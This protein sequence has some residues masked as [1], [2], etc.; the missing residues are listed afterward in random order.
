MSSRCREDFGLINIL[1]VDQRIRGRIQNQVE[2]N[3]REFYLTEQ[4]KAIHKELGREDQQSEFQQ[5]REK[6]VALKPSEEA[7]EKPFLVLGD[8][9]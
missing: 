2:K 8:Q 3:Q 7:L 5:L 4:I 6:I 1:E 9:I